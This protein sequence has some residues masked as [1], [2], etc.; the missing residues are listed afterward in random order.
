MK[1]LL[2][3]LM[4]IVFL[5][6]FGL[7]IDI[8]PAGSTEEPDKSAPDRIPEKYKTIITGRI[9][10]ADK[11]PI[12]GLSVSIYEASTH[13]WEAEFVETVPGSYGKIQQ[14]QNATLIFKEEKIHIYYA[15]KVK[16]GKSVNPQATT[17]SN[18]RFKIVADCRFWEKT[19]SF[20]IKGGFLPGTMIN[21]PILRQQSGKPILITIHKNERKV[22]LGDIVIE[23]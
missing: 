19:G 23:K 22:D 18:G 1:R 8:S 10:H 17:D 14:L 7:S 4:F 9:M 20:T 12:V 6:S 5:V 2:R 16:D 21:C 13:K 15:I 3:I 11:T